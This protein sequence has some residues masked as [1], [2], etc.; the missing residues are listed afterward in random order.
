MIVFRVCVS[1]RTVSRP[2]FF[3][4]L[5]CCQLPMLRQ[6]THEDATVFI[7]LPLDGLS[8]ARKRS[9]GRKELSEVFPIRF[10][11]TKRTASFLRLLALVFLFFCFCGE[12]SRRSYH[13]G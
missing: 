7:A 6:V 12:K 1:Q 4:Q 2:I 10:Y 11:F 5:L 8:R 9:I 3:L 13:H